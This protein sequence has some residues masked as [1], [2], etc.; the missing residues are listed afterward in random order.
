MINSTLAPIPIHHTSGQRLALLGQNHGQ[1]QQHHFPR[2]N[3]SFQFQRKL[4]MNNTYPGTLGQTF[5]AIPVG[6]KFT[7]AKPDPTI[8]IKR[9][10]STAIN[11][12]TGITKYINQFIRVYP[13]SPT[14]DK[15]QFL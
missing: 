4:T 9:T 11:T 1:I 15:T 12:Q 6:T 8:W 13:L 14:I 7:L 2:M 5:V 3:L 10:Q